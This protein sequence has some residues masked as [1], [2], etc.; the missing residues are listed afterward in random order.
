M[1]IKLTENVAY[2]DVLQLLCNVNIPITV[3]MKIF[4]GSGHLFQKILKVAAIDRDQKDSLANFPPLP[5]QDPSEIWQ[6][7]NGKSKFRLKATIKK[8]KI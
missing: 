4:H 8:C 3:W 1:N 5:A 7:Q 2:D 6:S